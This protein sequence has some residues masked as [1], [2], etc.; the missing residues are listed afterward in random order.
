MPGVV[1]GVSV[2]VGDRVFKGQEVCVIGK[3]ALGSSYTYLQLDDKCIIITLRHS[4][5]NYYLLAY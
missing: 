1:K 4:S 2:K 3:D 5:Q